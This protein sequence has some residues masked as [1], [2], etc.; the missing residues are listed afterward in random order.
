MLSA[1]HYE[2]RAKNGK[3]REAAVGPGK[4]KEHI[5]HKA[6]TDTVGLVTKEISIRKEK[7]HTSNTALQQQKG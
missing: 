2:Q 3:E 7:L 1:T 6:S 4:G 5:Y